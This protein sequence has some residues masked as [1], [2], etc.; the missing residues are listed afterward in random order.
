[1][2]DAMLLSSLL[3]Q[4]EGSPETKF[5]ESD[6][7]NISSAGFASL[8]KQKYLVFDQYDF[9]KESYFDN[10]GNE[11][12]IRKV[13]GKWIA[14]STDDPEISPIYLTEKDLNRHSFSVEPLLAEIIIPVGV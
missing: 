1:M 5:Y 3:K 10:Q 2:S 8:K 4:I 12:F 14:T 9:E 11:R 6:L 7:T 13:N